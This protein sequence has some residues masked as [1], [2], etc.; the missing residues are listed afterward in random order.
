M[1]FVARRLIAVELWITI[2]RLQ[3]LALPR[4]EKIYLATVLTVVALLVAQW[5]YPAAWPVLSTMLV[6]AL[7]GFVVG[8][9]SWAWPLVKARWNTERATV[10]KALFHVFAIL[11]ATG[12]ARGHVSKAMGLPAQDFD[13]TVHFVTLLMYLPACALILGPMLIIAHFVSMPIM[14]FVG[15][16]ARPSARKMTVI[17]HLAGLL[18]LGVCLTEFSRL[19]DENTPRLTSV[20]QAVAVWA[21][22]QPTTRYH[23]DVPAGLRI[24]LH[25]N[26]VVSWGQVTPTGV[27]LGRWELG[28]E[29]AP[30]IPPSR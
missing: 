22:Y 20:I 9:L 6:I 29:P 18:G 30:T 10:A 14:F 11:L 13:L 1:T 25:E 5:T 19:S 8:F 15:N 4:H 28:K 16:E 3:W 12:I 7:N 24:R 2:K 23:P 17:A 27:V 21:D 26:G